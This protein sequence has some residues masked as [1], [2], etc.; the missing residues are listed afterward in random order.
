M[1]EGTVTNRFQAI[2]FELM[3]IAQDYITSGQDNP[4]MRL[5]M[6]GVVM[7]ADSMLLALRTAMQPRS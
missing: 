1:A 5:A 7:M 3:G 6:N 4:D 2:C